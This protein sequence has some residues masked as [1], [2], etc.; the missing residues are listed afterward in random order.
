MRILY[1]SPYAP[2]R[3]GIGDYTARLARAVRARGHSVGVVSARGGEPSPGEV[4]GVLPHTRAGRAGLIAFVRGWR[5]DVI[6]VQFAV[7]A[8]GTATPAI[9]SLLGALRPLGVPVVVTYHEVTRDTGRLGA[10]GRVLYRVLT[11]R[12]DVVIVHTAAALRE[13][14]G[15][16]AA[17]PRAAAVVPHPAAELPEATVS[18]AEL[19]A[20]HGLDDWRVLLSFGFVHV[21]KGLGDLVAA[22]DWLRRLAPQQLVG[23][24]LVVAGDVRRR[25]GAFRAFEARDRV[26]LALVRARLRRLG[27]AR[28][29]VF[30]G[31]VPDGE[32]RPWFDLAEA[33]VLPYRR[34]EQSGVASLAV[35]A[36]CPVVASDAGG[37]GESVSDPRWSF[38]AGDPERL[39][40]VLR[41]LLAGEPDAL[42]HATPG[43]GGAPAAAMG[44]DA[45]VDATL[46]LYE[47]PPAGEAWP[48]QQVE[49]A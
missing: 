24:K 30:A 35:A 2:V 28:Q 11:R 4:L 18:A 36:G 14:T 39:A 1:V 40:A 12:A 26:H 43:A 31:Y 27:L 29:V 13:L 19:R 48:A 25:A 23:V 6:H 45:I 38:P 44:V 3:D 21:D 32:V 37:L 47:R 41:A 46:A 7:A 5:P 16:V 34:I 8:Y 42:R 49:H 9:V 15:P 22:L 20:R 33:A 10:P 17:R